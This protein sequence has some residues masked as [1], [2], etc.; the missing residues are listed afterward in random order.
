MDVEA[1]GI[2][3]SLIDSISIALPPASGNT[4]T[5]FEK[6]KRAIAPVRFQETQNEVRRVELEG[7]M[8]R[9]TYCK[10]LRPWISDSQAFFEAVG[11]PG[12]CES[13]AD[14][15][16][17]ILSEAQELQNTGDGTEAE[18]AQGRAPLSSDFVN[19]SIDAIKNV[20]DEEMRHWWARLIDDEFTAPGSFSKH[21]I[22][23]MSQMDGRTARLFE[24]LCAN[25]F[26]F[27]DTTSAK[28]ED[29]TREKPIPFAPN[30]LKTL[31]ELDPRLNHEAFSDLE[32]LGLATQQL[33]WSGTIAANTAGMCFWIGASAFILDNRS[34]TDFRFDT[35]I[36]FTPV[37]KEIFRLC[38]GSASPR[39]LDAIKQHCNEGGVEVVPLRQS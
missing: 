26:V 3:A 32:S 11:I 30:G 35:S 29:L 15:V 37:G 4:L 12:L 24:C 36:L 19:S 21:S 27:S 13:Q 14:N 25:S 2:K 18:D 39:L 23:V 5:V 9:A 20:S 16:M 1:N 10:T 17:A 33:T 31:L 28:I 6:V 22:A 38:R 34:D 8:E 7:V